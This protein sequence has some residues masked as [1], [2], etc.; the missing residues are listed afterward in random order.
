MTNRKISGK[1]YD[2]VL[3]VWNKFEMKTIKAYHELYLKYNVLL[4]ADAFKN[5]EIIT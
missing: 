1:E 3:K 4:L 2:V 5:L